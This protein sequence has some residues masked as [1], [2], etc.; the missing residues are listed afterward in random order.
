MDQCEVV[1]E[2]NKVYVLDTV[3]QPITRIWELGNSEHNLEHL[4]EAELVVF[5]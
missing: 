3:S 1:I 4:L 2:K 5:C